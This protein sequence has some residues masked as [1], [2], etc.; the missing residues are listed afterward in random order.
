MVVDIDGPIETQHPRVE[1]R[2]AYDFGTSSTKV[3]FRII[4]RG[5]FAPVPQYREITGAIE[6]IQFPNGQFFVPT[7]VAW[8]KIKD[9]N[10]QEYR[11]LWGHEV[12]VAHTLGRISSD[13][14]FKRLKPIVFE[15]NNPE[16]GRI[17]AKISQLDDTIRRRRR[18]GTESHEAEFAD[19][20]H[21]QLL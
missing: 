2:I 12:T 8:E 14:V 16:L 13:D 10:P 7:Q 6:T 1:V 18:S 20:D 4:K 17:Q 15:E 5:V 9:T 19:I 3:A 11:Q 21:L